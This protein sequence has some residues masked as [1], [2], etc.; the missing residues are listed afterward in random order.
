MEGLI[1][2]NGHINILTCWKHIKLKNYTTE[3][4]SDKYSANLLL[5]DIP[6]SIETKEGKSGGS[7]APM[8]SCFSNLKST[9]NHSYFMDGLK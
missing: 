2:Y 7:R 4:S 8:W 6:K 1:S 5:C 3:F 9:L